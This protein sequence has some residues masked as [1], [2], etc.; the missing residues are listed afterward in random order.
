MP[1]ITPS[2]S[3]LPQENFPALPL[4]PPLQLDTPGVILTPV[5]PDFRCELD[6]LWK[7]VQITHSNVTAQIKGTLEPLA[8][9][10]QQGME[11]TH[12]NLQRL[13]R[14]C[15]HVA[16]ETQDMKRELHPKSMRFCGMNNH[17]KLELTGRFRISLTS[18]LNWLEHV[19]ASL[20][21]KIM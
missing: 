13:E 4:A 11:T 15:K 18:C 9:R 16:Q 12:E 6:C 1:N 19:V 20:T 5:P 17:S 10:L 14:M 2:P 7:N 3:P 21:Y 8:G